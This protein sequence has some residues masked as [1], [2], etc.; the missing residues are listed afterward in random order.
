MVK[1]LFFT[2]YPPEDAVTR[3]R[4]LHYFPF[5]K[6]SAIQPT[7][8][9]FMSS[10]LYAIKN[11]PDLPGVICKSAYLL[12]NLFRRLAV[13]PSVRHYDVVFFQREVFPFFTPVVEHIACRMNPRLIFDFDDAIFVRPTYGRNW[14]DILRDPSRVADVVQLSAHVTAGNSYLADYARRFNP[15]V[16]IIPTTIDTDRYRVRNYSNRLETVTIGWIGSWNTTESLRLL[17]GVFRELYARGHKFILKLVGANN[18]DTLDFGPV[19][20]IK[21]RWNVASE[22]DEL[23]SF[24]IG[25]MPL[26]ATAWDRGKCGFKILQYMAVG[27]PAVASAV[28]ANAEIICDGQNGFLAASYKQWIEKLILLIKNPDL[29]RQLGLQ[30]RATIEERYSV[31]AVAPE[32]VRVIQMVA[33]TACQTSPASDSLP[34]AWS[35]TRNDG[36]QTDSSIRGTNKPGHPV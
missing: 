31:K 24:D 3:H 13:L 32:L 1:V 29:R 22:I 14:R 36:A 30:G 19:P 5:L 33:D 35:C 6:R 26:Q 15:N 20:T 7:L 8:R 16:T 9:P 28:G 21:R 2:P 17:D 18:L 25:V 10:H 34:G 4:V 12:A 11:R 27:V 23:Q